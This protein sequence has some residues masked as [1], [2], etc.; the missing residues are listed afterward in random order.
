LRERQNDKASMLP[1]KIVLV[2]TTGTIAADTMVAAAA[3][4][5][6]AGDARR[7]SGVS[8]PPSPMDPIQTALHRVGLFIS[9]TPGLHRL[10]SGQ[11]TSYAVTQRRCCP[12]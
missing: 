9:E 6:R 4:L 8:A 10:I 5:E 7:A 2:D 1:I 11:T 3:A 12:L